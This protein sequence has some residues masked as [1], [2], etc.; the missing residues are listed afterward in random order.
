M[1]LNT[2]KKIGARVY[3]DDLL[4]AWST[5][6]VHFAAPNPIAIDTT[7]VT[8]NDEKSTLFNYWQ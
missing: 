6:H 3:W 2:L 4:A 7:K 5:T 1:K 8:T